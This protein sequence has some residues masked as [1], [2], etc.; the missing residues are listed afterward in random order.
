MKKKYRSTILIWVSVGIMLF[1]LGQMNV[2]FEEDKKPK[3]LNL[4]Y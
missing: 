2:E 1:L 4:V 3:G